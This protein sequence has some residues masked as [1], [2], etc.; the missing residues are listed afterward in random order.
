VVRAELVGERFDVV[1]DVGD[2]F[3]G[4]IVV[5]HHHGVADA[6]LLVGILD[7]L[8]EIVAVNGARLAT[9]EG[10]GSELPQCRG[11]GSARRARG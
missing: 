2:L 9:L 3:V 6:F 5:R 10:D 1:D 7:R 11:D 8:N 4:E